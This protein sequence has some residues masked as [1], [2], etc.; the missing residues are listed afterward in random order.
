VKLGE[1]AGRQL[2][3]P[4]SEAELVSAVREA[5]DHGR[6]ILPI[7]RGAQLAWC[8]VPESA[9]LLIS[10]ER[11]TGVVAHVPA[12]GTIAARAGT[13]V[14][15]LRSTARAGGHFATP[16]VPEPAAHTL[17]GILA[18]GQ[19]G[20]DRLRFGPARHHV[21]G[22]K[23]L[24]A[25]GTVAKSGGQLVKNVTGYDLH[26]LY[27]GSHG[28]L[29]VI[30]EVALR[31]FPEPED[32]RYL[33]GEARGTR[34]LLACARALADP[35]LRP[36]SV[37]FERSAGERWRFHL[38]LA[39]LREVLERERALATEG[40]PRGVELV[41]EAR[42]DEARAAAELARDRSWAHR[43]GPFARASGPPSILPAVLAEVERWGSQSLWIEPGLAAVELALPE[44]GAERADAALR[45]LGQLPGLAL[46]VFDGRSGP[47]PLLA[48]AAPTTGV[49]LMRAL[50]RRLDPN[51][52]FARE[53]LDW[54]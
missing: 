52:L 15:N 30:L 49:E 53:P 23:V 25:D 54:A 4:E 27:C 24:L 7:G 42:G 37:L 28:S 31:L 21:L 13:S 12:D 16:D 38:R 39:G 51:G 47:W 19:S 8:G 22:M 6:R 50:K 36:L 45:R 18:A 5:R 20:P 14:A 40:L 33:A 46:Q 1:L 41:A 43:A 34:G 2:L 11:L 29:C 10:T 26:R 48:R 35:R 32:E 9:D 44:G 3:A 17:G